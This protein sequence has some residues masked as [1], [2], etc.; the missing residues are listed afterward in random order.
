M[1]RVTKKQLREQAALAAFEQALREL[2]DPRRKQGQRYPLESVVV[3][4]LMAMICNCDDAESMQCWGE[5]SEEWLSGFLELPHGVPTQDVFLSVF[6]ALDPDA[7]NQVFQTWMALLIPNLDMKNSHIAID[8]KTSRRSFIRKSNGK[9]KPALHTVSAYM[10][11]LGMVL[12]QT[13]T[14]K[15]SNEITA[16]PTLLKTLDI[17]GAVVT[18]D[19]M[20]CQKD[21]AKVIVE[22]GGDYLLAVKSNQRTLHTDITAAFEDVQDQEQRADGNPKLQATV[23][24]CREKNHGRIEER[25]VH[26]CRDLS[27]LPTANEWEN[28]TTIVMVESKRTELSTQK[29]S[30]EK[31]YYIGSSTDIDV[32]TA[33]HFVRRHWSIENELHWVLDMA[34]REDGSRHRSK[35]CGA[36]FAVL[37]HF[38]VN[39]LKLD[40]TN[41]LGISNKRKVA[42]YNRQYLM[43]VLTGV[44]SKK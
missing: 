28:L 38:A 20:G 23:H 25:T 41:K 44:S 12:G 29:V 21:I 42:S 40:T 35:N 7:F 13:K 14:A 34:F 19:A 30:T 26:L 10:S 8:G 37:R 31:R 22:R 18:I 16:I 6:A 33:G 36:N 3:I 4:A 17:K 5:H 39:L 24:H 9:R 27:H 32:K 43:Q 1:A 2:P 11:R 15:K